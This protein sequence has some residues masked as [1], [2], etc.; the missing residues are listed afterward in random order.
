MPPLLTPAV[1]SVARVQLGHARPHILANHDP[2]R[3]VP[4]GPFT[5]ADYSYERADLC[6][7]QFGNCRVPSL[8]V[9]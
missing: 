9:A 8:G 3:N 6:H 1:I 2:L 7:A 4:R 5:L